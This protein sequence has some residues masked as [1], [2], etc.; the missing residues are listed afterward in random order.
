MENAR[1]YALR[2]LFAVF[3]LVC[4]WF[5]Q[6]NDVRVGGREI[7]ELGHAGG[8]LVTEMAVNFHGQCATIFVT[9]PAGNGYSGLIKPVADRWRDADESDRDGRAPR[10]ANPMATLFLEMLYC[11]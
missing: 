1:I 4:L 11:C 2:A 7:D 10:D 5:R 8:I 3:W 6:W 9:K